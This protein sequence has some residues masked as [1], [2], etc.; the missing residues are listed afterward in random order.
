MGKGKSDGLVRMTESFSIEIGV[1][2]AEH[3]E[4]PEDDRVAVKVGE[5]N[6]SLPSV[7]IINSGPLAFGVASV[8]LG[9]GSDPLAPIVFIRS[10]AQRG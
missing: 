6:S 10:A 2:G 4:L 5:R 9:A 7:E 1:G 3:A 8:E